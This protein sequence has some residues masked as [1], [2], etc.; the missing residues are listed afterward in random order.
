M[1]NLEPICARYGHRM[2][3]GEN[4]ISLSDQENTIRN[5]LGVLVE[6]GLY[7]MGIFLLSCKKKEY[8]KKILTTHL[9]DLWKEPGLNLMP[10]NTSATPADVL[11]G[12]QAITEDLPTLI[13]ARKVTEQALTFARYHAKA[14]VPAP[15]PDLQE[16]E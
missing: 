6:N 1:V 13:L 2:I 5:A 12:V 10:E 9:A 15:S 3:E 14:G 11:T 7:A 8:G 4:S 16:A